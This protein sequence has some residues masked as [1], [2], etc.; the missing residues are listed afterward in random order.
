VRLRQRGPDPRSVAMEFLH[1]AA[2]P[3]APFRQGCCALGAAARCNTLRHLAPPDAAAAQGEGGPAD[4][5]RG[6]KPLLAA[7][8]ASQ[9]AERL[10]GLEARGGKCAQSDRAPAPQV[11]P[12]QL[13][14]AACATV[15]SL[16][17]AAHQAPPPRLPPLC[18]PPTHTTT[19]TRLCPCLLRI[20]NLELLLK[21]GPNSW[22]AH[23][24]TLDATATRLQGEL[25]GLRA[26]VDGTN[27]E[28]KLQQE[29]AGECCWA[30]WACWACRARQ[31]RVPPGPRPA[32]RF[33]HRRLRL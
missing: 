2:P 26:T 21:Y 5:I 27:R 18:H 25:V 16:A 6:H 32:S 13:P 22:R 19:H 31:G 24:Q 9:Q 23:N 3:D 8:A 12:R 28:R 20:L 7:Q 30:C 17:P 10:R 33:Y 11:R 15:S 1:P 4:G 29:A 14:L